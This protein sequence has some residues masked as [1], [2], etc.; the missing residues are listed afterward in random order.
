MDC[1]QSFL[2]YLLDSVLMAPWAARTASKAGPS[3]VV[4]RILH[5]TVARKKR[6]ERPYPGHT[7]AREAEM[8][9]KTNVWILELDLHGRSV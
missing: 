4:L 6:R 9:A 2:Y 8:P 3:Y 5:V 1:V 7:C